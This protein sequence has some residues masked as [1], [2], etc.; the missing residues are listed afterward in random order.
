MEK[1]PNYEEVNVKLRNT[2]L[3]KL[4]SAAKNKTVTILTI[5]KKNFQDEEL[6]HELFLT[7]TQ[8]TKIRNAFANIMSAGIKLSKAQIYTIIQSGGFLRNILG[9]LG[10]KV[11]TDLAVPLAR[12]D[13]PG[14]VRNLTSNAINRF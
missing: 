9:N 5:N 11:I 1:I 3:N 10:R 13:L 8:T 2:Q 4:N 7:T 12:D 6:T 14:L